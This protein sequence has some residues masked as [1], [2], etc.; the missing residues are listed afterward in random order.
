MFWNITGSVG[1]GGANRAADVE[2][3]ATR[4]K[5]IG[6]LQG[7]GMSM[8]SRQQPTSALAA[9][10]AGSSSGPRM[11]MAPTPPANPFAGRPG[12]A[13][14][15]AAGWNIDAIIVSIKAFQRDFLP[16]PD[17]LISPNGTSVQLLR[18][19][20]VKPIDNGVQLPGRLKEAWDL[21]NPL[22]PAGSRCTSGFRSAEEQRAI[23]HRF[24]KDKYKAAIIAK[25]GQASYDAANTNLVA[26]EDKVLEMVRGVGQQI[27]RPGSSKH[28]Q[29]KAIDV[30]GPDKI[31]PEQVRVIKMVAKA[32][33][34]LLSGVVLKER[35]GCVHFELR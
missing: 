16:A 17:G 5:M 25:Y 18:N 30:G 31:D 27:A 21:V 20:S 7:D 15:P 22:L 3:V 6:K 19:W 33:P 14:T 8:M 29:G 4:L 13:S 23:L 35:N 11:S 2:A 26:N 10:A 28:Q 9:Y 1:M 24:F 34:S 12:M 32:N